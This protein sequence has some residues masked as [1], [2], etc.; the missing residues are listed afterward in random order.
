[1]YV[2][3]SR[4]G[5]ASSTHNGQPWGP[6][7]VCKAL[8][9]HIIPRHNVS[10]IFTEPER[11]LLHFNLLHIP[12]LYKKL[13]ILNIGWSTQRLT[14]HSLCSV[15]CRSTICVR[16]HKITVYLCLLPSFLSVY[17]LYLTI[18]LY[19]IPTFIP[20]LLIRTH[21]KRIVKRD[22]LF[23]MCVPAPCLTNRLPPTRKS[24]FSYRRKILPL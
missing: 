16:I 12:V 2:T 20:C 23:L 5:H 13:S 18:L 15:L 22:M 21:E 8:I 4:G 7:C 3:E 19:F 24:I 14:N 9:W 1:M 11:Y 17:Y 10:L 6:K